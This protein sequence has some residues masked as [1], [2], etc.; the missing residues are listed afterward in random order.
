MAKTKL[1]LERDHRLFHGAICKMQRAEEIGDI[2]GAVSAA[3]DS[4]RYLDGMLQ[5]E[6]RYLSRAEFATIE[7]I[8]F[9]LN[10]APLVFDVKSLNTLESHLKSTRRIE[11]CTTENLSDSLRRARGRLNQAGRIWTHLEHHSPSAVEALRSLVESDD[12]DPLM[13]IRIWQELGLVDVFDDECGRSVRLLNFGDERVCGKCP[14]CGVVG[15][16]S[17]SEFLEE[18][19][20]P[21][22]QTSVDIVL[23][24]LV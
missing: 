16:G 8:D 17:V 21:L 9:A 19:T 23:L 11:K 7:S 2:P 18:R 14:S 4:W 13:A 6:R 10:F 24:P 22:C 12:F 1:Q 20:C 3:V 5:Y 15:N